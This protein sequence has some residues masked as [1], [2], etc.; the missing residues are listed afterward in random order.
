MNST[1]WK[2]ND[3]L[4]I[5]NEHLKWTKKINNQIKKSGK[6]WNNWTHDW[7]NGVWLNCGLQ[8]N[9]EVHL[10]ALTTGRE[11]PAVGL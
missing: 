5:E 3:H 9:D 1:M 8:T 4:N 11:K 7:N 6:H 2:E 10:R